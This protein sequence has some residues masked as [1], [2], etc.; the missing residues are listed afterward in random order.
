MFKSLVLLFTECASAQFHVISQMHMSNPGLV[1]RGRGRAL[2]GG[3]GAYS[4]ASSTQ[5]V[6]TAVHT[7]DPERDIPKG[8]LPEAHPLEARDCHGFQRLCKLL[9]SGLLWAYGAASRA[10]ACNVCCKFTC[11]DPPTRSGRWIHN[12][13]ARNVGLL[14][15]PVQDCVVWAGLGV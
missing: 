4:H 10:E 14:G 3:G 15:A 11:S 5:C 7:F 12:G 1:A 9:L 2:S 6:C 13:C 8:E